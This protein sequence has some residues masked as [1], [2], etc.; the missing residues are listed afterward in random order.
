MCKY[1]V[2]LKIIPFFLSA[3]IL[4]SFSTFLE[5]RFSM[6]TL[7][8]FWCIKTIYVSKIHTK[9]FDASSIVSIGSS[10]ASTIVISAGTNTHSI[11]IVTI[12]N[13][14]SSIIAIVFLTVRLKVVVAEPKLQAP[15]YNY[16]FPHHC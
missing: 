14:N 10:N 13:G 4:T 11:V 2:N 16:R 8:V 3:S 6:L 1:K 9:N 15:S 5:H 7:L 12:G